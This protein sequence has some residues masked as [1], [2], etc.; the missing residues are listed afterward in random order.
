MAYLDF[1]A[2]KEKVDL[3]EAAKYLG[4][5][6]RIKGNQFR[7]PC[8]ACKGGD[9][10]LAITP[11]KGF[12][13]FGAQKGGRDAIA[14][15]AHVRDCGM[16]QAA[17]ELWERYCTPS[18]KGSSKEEVPGTVPQSAEAKETQKFQPLAYLR[19]DHEA[20][21]A[22]GFDPAIAQRL[23]IGYAPKG[24]LR[25][26]VAVPIRDESGELIAYIGITEATLPRSLQPTEDDPKVVRFPQTA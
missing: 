4:L 12:Y 2:I 17:Q 13:C 9:R 11:G 3:E 18:G 1:E 10:Q 24:V 23:G 16:K 22:V 25:G 8:P 20:V 19:A 7:S 21:E 14:L 15:V 6:Y 26:T 5:Q